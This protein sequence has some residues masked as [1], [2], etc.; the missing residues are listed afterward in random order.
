MYIDMFVWK[1]KYVFVL[2]D[3]GESDPFIYVLEN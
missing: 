1:V 3:E 2:I